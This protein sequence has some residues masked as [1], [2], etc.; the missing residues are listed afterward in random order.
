MLSVGSW[1]VESLHPIQLVWRACWQMKNHLQRGEREREKVMLFWV[2]SNSCV[3]SYC[4]QRLQWNIP[5]LVAQLAFLFFPSVFLGPHPRHVEVPRL[6]VK[7]ELQLPA[8]T[9]APAMRDPSHICDPHHSSQQCHILN[10]L[11]ET[12]DQT[13]VL[14]DPG[15]VLNPLSHNGHS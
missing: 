7:S 1:G 15:R 13:H 10:P 4:V 3:P 9:T 12:R 14:M 2:A 6:R 8:Y 5:W 11:S